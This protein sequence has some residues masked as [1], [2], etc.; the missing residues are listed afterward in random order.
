MASFAG[1]DKFA[2]KPPTDPQWATFAAAAAALCREWD[3]L[4]AAA[5]GGWGRGDPRISAEK[6]VDDTLCNFSDRWKAGKTLDWDEVANF[7]ALSMDDL[8]DCDIEQGVADPLSKVLVNL[9][10]DCRAGNLAGAEQLLRVRAE[11][12]AVTAAAAE[13]ERLAKAVAAP[14]AAETGAGSMECEGAEAAA[15]AVD[16]DG[17]QTV[18]RKGRKGRR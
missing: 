9:F 4:R 2:W 15:P 3:V 11:A 6:I 13:A 7:F 16:D 17:F 1:D 10:D 18:V 5:Q 8:F 14:P 12:A